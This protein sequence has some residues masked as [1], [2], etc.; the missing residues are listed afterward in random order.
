[1]K[2]LIAIT[3]VLTLLCTPTLAQMTGAPA[4]AQTDPANSGGMNSP[5]KGGM[6]KGKSMKKS[7]A[8]KKNMGA[9]DDMTKNSMS[10]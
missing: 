1:M 10:K 2:T 5:D 6:K 3:A 7:S 8:Q 4:A 9:K